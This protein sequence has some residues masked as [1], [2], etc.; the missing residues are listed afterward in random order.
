MLAHKL[1]EGQE[2]SHFLQILLASMCSAEAEIKSVV[3][4]VFCSSLRVSQAFRMLV[5]DLESAQGPLLS[6][7]SG[8]LPLSSLPTLRRPGRRRWLQGIRVLVLAGR[9]GVGL[10]VSFGHPPNHDSLKFT[11]SLGT[12]SHWGTASYYSAEAPPLPTSRLPEQGAGC[13]EHVCFLL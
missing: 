5:T 1:K 11:T 7:P 2:I 9:L 13:L 12:T 3:T 4:R 6:S 10:Q 8:P